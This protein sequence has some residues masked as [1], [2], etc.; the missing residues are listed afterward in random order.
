MSKNRKRPN[1][2]R[3][4]PAVVAEMA[5]ELA[6]NYAVTNALKDATLPERMII[7]ALIPEVIRVIRQGGSIGIVDVAPSFPPTGEVD[8]EFVQ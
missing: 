3:G 7:A 8:A 4:M 6:G 5:A 1:P 2:A